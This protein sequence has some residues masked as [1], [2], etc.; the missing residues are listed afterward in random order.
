MDNDFSS[1][2]SGP[3]PRTGSS[4][5]SSWQEVWDRDAHQ[6]AMNM[7]E[8]PVYRPKRATTEEGSAASF[9]DMDDEPD[10]ETLEE[11]KKLETRLAILKDKART[12]SGN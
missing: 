9:K 2:L 8:K 3:Y 4:P 1:N 7:G 6:K 10:A 5:G 11:I 12:K